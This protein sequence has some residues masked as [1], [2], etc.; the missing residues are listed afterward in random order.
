MTKNYTPVTFRIETLE[1]RD[2]PMA[3]G[4]IINGGAGVASAMTGF[5]EFKQANPD[6]NLGQILQAH[7]DY[8][9]A[10]LTGPVS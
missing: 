3:A 5:G 2:A 4:S 9:D 7:T 6:A 10:P 8:Y 1:N